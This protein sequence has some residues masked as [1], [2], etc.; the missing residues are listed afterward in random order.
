[1]NNENGYYDISTN[2]MVQGA[3]D[4]S[5]NCSIVEKAWGREVII[6]NNRLYC[7]KILVFNSGAK[8]SMHFHM[9]KTETWF[10][11]RGSFIMG[12]IDTTNA[13]KHFKE[14]KQG[15][16]IHI[17]KGQPHQLIAGEEGGEIFEVS[18]PHFDY[19]S[20]RVE[21]GDSQNS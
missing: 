12:Y 21:R 19:D 13:T 10:V 1:M 14:L 8:F 15:D 6:T 16:I 7:G 17:R 9:E 20:Y 5:T 11:S 18:T 4:F 3:P 2:Q